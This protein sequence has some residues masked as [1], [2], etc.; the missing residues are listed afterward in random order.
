VN[1][2]YRKNNN[3][4]LIEN[5]KITCKK[6]APVPLGPHKSNEIKI[7]EV[8]TTLF[9]SAFLLFVF[10]VNEEKKSENCEIVCISKYTLLFSFPWLKS[11]QCAKASSLLR[12]YYHTQDTPHS[13]VLLW[14]SD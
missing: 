3:N 9:I 5:N 4:I 13:V 12:I 11:P 10:A 7:W 2:E 14:T 6:S 1:A 8:Q